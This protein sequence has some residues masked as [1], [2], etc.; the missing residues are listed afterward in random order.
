MNLK[1]W[2]HEFQKTQFSVFFL[3][4]D[5]FL[6]H[7]QFSVRSY[8]CEWIY[9]HLTNNAMVFSFS[10]F[11]T[12][13]FNLFIFW[14]IIF[15]IYHLK[16]FFLNFFNISIYNFFDSFKWNIKFYIASFQLEFS[17]KMNLTFLLIHS[18]LLKFHHFCNFAVSWNKHLTE[19]LITHFCL[20]HSTGR[21]ACWLPCF[22]T[23]FLESVSPIPCTPAKIN[24]PWKVQQYMLRF[25][26]YRTF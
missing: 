16:S 21:F 26:S 24:W 4:S 20:F 14:F 25:W 19:L 10:T 13:Y 15:F 2:I 12:F 8:L 7:R 9:G 17:E 5:K 11:D 22:G 18:V 6:G 23:H 3:C 1:C